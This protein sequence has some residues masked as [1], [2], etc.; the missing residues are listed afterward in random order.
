VRSRISKAS[1]SQ[2]SPQGFPYAAPN[3]ATTDPTDQE[4]GFSFFSPFSFTPGSS[5]QFDTFLMQGSYTTMQR[6]TY[7]IKRR[8]GPFLDIAPPVGEINSTPA[9]GSTISGQISVDGWPFDCNSGT[10]SVDL[11]VDDVLKASGLANIT[12]P[13]IA[14][15]YPGAPSNP[16][17]HFVLDTRQLPNGQHVIEVRATDAAGNIGRLPHRIVTVDN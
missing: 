11:Y 17:F 5:V 2:P 1:A 8:L 16:A 4:L 15:A 13:D 9:T 14:G 6:E 12:R 10:T 3:Q 7:D